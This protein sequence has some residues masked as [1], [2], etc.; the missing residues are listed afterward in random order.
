MS[1]RTLTEQLYDQTPA[2]ILVP[3]GSTTDIRSFARTS[4]TA[5]KLDGLELLQLFRRQGLNP[6]RST[7]LI[8]LIESTARLSDALLMAKDHEKSYADLFSALQVSRIVDAINTVTNDAPLPRILKELLDGDID[9]LARSQS[10][11][12][13]TLWELELLRMMRANG[14][15]AV[16]DEP[17]LLLAGMADEIG[18]A[19]KKLY[20]EANFSKVISVAVRQIRRSLKLGLVAVNIDDL[21]P[22]NTILSAD[23]QEVASQM[24]NIRIGDF[25][26]RQER[27]LRHYLEPGRAIAI[28]VSCAALADLKHNVNRPG[29]RGGHLV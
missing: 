4:V 11:A 20:S 10:K 8:R 9:L 6:N 5:A 2:G 15:K 3:S 14:V 21:L 26:A 18:V 28:L 23:S 25:M 13:D 7:S 16:L 27:Y 24:M 22:A 17:D 12:K 29:F 1:R 19:C